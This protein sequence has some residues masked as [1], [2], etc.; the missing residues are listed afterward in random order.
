MA[1]ASLMA[2]FTAATTDAEL[3][4]MSIAVAREHGLHVTQDELREISSKNYREFLE[5]WI[6]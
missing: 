5:R 3:H 6:P 2:A 4:S 1:D